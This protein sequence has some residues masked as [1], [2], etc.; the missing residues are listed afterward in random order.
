MMFYLATIWHSIDSFMASI[1]LCGS[2]PLQTD[3]ILTNVFM[4]CLML[5]EKVVA[6]PLDYYKN[7]HLEEKWG[8]NKMTM[9]TFIKD[10][11][12]TFVLTLVF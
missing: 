7:F 10:L 12:K 4:T 9:S 3:F 1:N 11:I 5:I 2:T 6:I 8:Y